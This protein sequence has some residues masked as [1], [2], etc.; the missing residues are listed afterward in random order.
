MRVRIHD[1]E[2]AAAFM[3]LARLRPDVVLAPAPPTAGGDGST[4]GDGHNV[5]E[6]G[7]LGSFNSEDRTIEM[8]SLLRSW[9]SQLRGRFREV[10]VEVVS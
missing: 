5:F 1:S 9:T 3:G 7:L 10:G 6:V 2:V 4:S 8:A